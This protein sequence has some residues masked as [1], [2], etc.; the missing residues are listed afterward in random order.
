MRRNLALAGT[1]PTVVGVI[2]VLDALYSPICPGSLINGCSYTAIY[3]KLYLGIFL[4]IVGAA[5]ALISLRM[6]P[7]SSTE[8]QPT[9]NI[10]KG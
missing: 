2:L 9:E 6:K 1:A 4:L 7:T 10:A 8:K 3:E 5:I